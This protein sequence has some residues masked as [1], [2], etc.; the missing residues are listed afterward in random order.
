MT[1]TGLSADLE[2]VREVDSIIVATVGSDVAVKAIPDDQPEKERMVKEI[3]AP[4]GRRLVVRV[5]DLVFPATL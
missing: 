1:T 4:A 2:A 5:G 3:V